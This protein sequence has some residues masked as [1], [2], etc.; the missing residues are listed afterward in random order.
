MVAGV[1]LAVGSLLHPDEAAAGF[2]PDAV[3]MY[4]HLGMGAGLALAA[5]GLSAYAASVDASM[6]LIGRCSLIILSIGTGLASGLI[7]FVEEFMMPTFAESV[8]FAPLLDP[9]GPLFG[10]IFGMSFMVLFAVLSIA[11]V[12]SGFYIAQHMSSQQYIGYLFF[13]LPLAAFT[14]PLPHIVGTIGGIVFG[15]ALF[16]LGKQMKDAPASL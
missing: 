16:L 8:A 6:N 11:A 5:F 2:M 9:A 12:A 10:G 4:V 14:P 1:L 13:A 3:W 7:L 15:A